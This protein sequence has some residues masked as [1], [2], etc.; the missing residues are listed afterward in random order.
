MTQ[1]SARSGHFFGE[2]QEIE[3]R[4]AYRP[5]YV[6]LLLGYLGA[7]PNAAILEAGCGSGFLS[8]LLARELPNVSVIGLD[9]D[10]RSLTIARELQ[11]AEQIGSHLRF[12]Q[13]DTHRLPFADDSFDLV[14]S[15]RLL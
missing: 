1:P 9:S 5:E 14:T 2:R 8:R 10:E 3:L 11:E 4:Y 15:H 13:G 12:E 7:K 6:P